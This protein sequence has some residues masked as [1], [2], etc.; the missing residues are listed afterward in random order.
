MGSHGS[1]SAGKL[2]FPAL[3]HNVLVCPARVKTTL[4]LSGPGKLEHPGKE[5]G[6]Q[7]WE[8]WCQVSRPHWW[9]KQGDWRT[10]PWQR[11]GPQLPSVLNHVTWLNN[12]EYIRRDM[13]L[14]CP[15]CNLVNVNSQ[16]RDNLTR[17][18]TWDMKVVGSTSSIYYSPS[19]LTLD[20]TMWFDF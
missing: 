11:H 1:V 10:H 9:W 2:I 7:V 5:G 8:H 15:G 17:V 16:V 13:A 3:I 18:F 12:T 4:C 14:K 20:W 19:I 6:T